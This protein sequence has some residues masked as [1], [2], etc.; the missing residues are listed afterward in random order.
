MV[1]ENVEGRIVLNQPAGHVE[2]G[3][4]MIDAVMRETLEETAHHFTPQAVTGIYFWQHPVNGI[5]Y[6]RHAFCGIVEG[7]DNHLE[8]DS[9]I[10]R[11]VW[12]TPEELG[13]QP[14]R[15]RSPLVMKTIEGYLQGHRYGLELYQD[16]R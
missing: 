8:L 13:A 4:S 11:A 3:E 6:V 7:P 15:L 1:E 12:L 14:E 9:D 10:L 16:I 5:T 2:A